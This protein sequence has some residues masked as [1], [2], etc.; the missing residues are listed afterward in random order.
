MTIKVN[1]EVFPLAETSM[2]DI[3]AIPHGFKLPF[4][5]LIM[6]LVIYED[7]VPLTKG[8]QVDIGVIMVPRPGLSRLDC[9]DSCVI[10]LFGSFKHK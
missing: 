2:D 6:G 10:I 1:E 4:S 3:R 5:S 7:K 8:A 9:L